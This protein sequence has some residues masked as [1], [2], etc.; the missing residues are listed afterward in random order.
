M[1]CRLNLSPS[2][3]VDTQWFTYRVGQ[4]RRPLRL[5]VY[6]FK[7]SELICVMYAVVVARNLRL[8]GVKTHHDSSTKHSDRGGGGWV[9]TTSKHSRRTSVRPLR[10]QSRFYI[11][12]LVVGLVYCV[13]YFTCFYFLYNLAYWLQY[14]N[15][16]TYLLTY[17]GEDLT[18]HFGFWT[19]KASGQLCRPWTVVVGVASGKWTCR[20]R[21]NQ[22]S[23]QSSG[24]YSPIG[25]RCLP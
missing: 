22:V 13:Y 12:L 18:R 11:T 14:L 21:D 24:Q 20:S 25:S 9:P 5:T 15:K 6:I 8:V 19:A 4:K 23:V 16:L 1:F 7:T 10:L 17:L 2:M 3:P